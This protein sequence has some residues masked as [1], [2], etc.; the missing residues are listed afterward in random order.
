MTLLFRKKPNKPKNPNLY[1]LGDIIFQVQTRKTVVKATLRG[2]LCQKPSVLVLNGN[3]LY[4]SECFQ[5]NTT[6]FAL[7]ELVIYDNRGKATA[8]QSED[9]DTDKDIFPPVTLLSHSIFLILYFDQVASNCF[10]IL[11]IK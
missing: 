6:M 7:R 10:S 3:Q 9:K 4:C 5:K 2:A 11:L 8:L 1:F